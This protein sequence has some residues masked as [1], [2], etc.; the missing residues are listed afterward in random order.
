[1]ITLKKKKKHILKLLDE[2]SVAPNIS[3]LDSSIFLSYMSI[4]IYYNDFFS[5]PFFSSGT[6]KEGGK[7]KQ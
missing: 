7:N 6:K 1:M 4:F 5:S 3:N 2:I